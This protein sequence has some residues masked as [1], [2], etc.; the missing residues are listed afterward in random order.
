MIV[1]D[2]RTRY[3]LNSPCG[4][5][6]KIRVK[7]FHRAIADFLHLQHRCLLASP[8]QLLIGDGCKAAQ[9]CVG[10]LSLAGGA[11]ELPALVQ[12]T[13]RAARI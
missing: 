8:A 9:D 1:A 4:L 12:I 10:N 2:L 7:T 11:F 6:G 3:A 5:S 13:L